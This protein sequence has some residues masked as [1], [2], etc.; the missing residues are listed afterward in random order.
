MK[1]GM[2]DVRTREGGRGGKMMLNDFAAKIAE[3]R[4]PISEAGERFYGKMWRPE[5]FG[6]Q[7]EE[8]KQDSPSPKPEP[9]KAAN[10]VDI[11][12][13]E[14]R[15]KNNTWLGGASP[16]KE[17][18]DVSSGLDITNMDSKKYPRAYAWYSLITKFT[19]KKKAEWPAK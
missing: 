3:E 15:L 2:I 12:S 18:A 11:A 19:D 13:I 7:S 5:D 1:S 6:G 17:D 16:S 9:K 10:K 14:D 4:P 8:V